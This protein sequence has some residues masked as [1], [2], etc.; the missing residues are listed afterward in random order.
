MKSASSTAERP[1]QR[2]LQLCQLAVA[3][4]WFYH[5]LVPKLLGPAADELRMDRALGLSDSEAVQLAYIAGSCEIVFAAIV[6]IFRKQEWPLWLTIFAM[7]G[8][9]AFAAW[10][11]PPLLGAAFNPVSTN[12]CVA[13]LA[14]VALL[15][16]RS[17][18][19]PEALG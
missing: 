4:V 10:A 9:L 18:G 7:V 14:A 19:R 15:L 2:A 8:L 5:G 1:L 13:V 6:L 11:S 12:V 16:Q 3:F 17:L